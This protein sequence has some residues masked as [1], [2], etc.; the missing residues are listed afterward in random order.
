MPDEYNAC[1]V[2]WMNGPP[3][4]ITSRM[5]SDHIQKDT[6]I[7][8]ARGYVVV[9]F[10]A[11]N[12]GYWFLHCHVECHLLEGMAVLIKEY[13]HTQHSVRNNRSLSDYKAFSYTAPENRKRCGGSQP[14]GARMDKA[15]PIAIA[16]VELI[17]VLLVA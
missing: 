17:A 8:P 15:G 16:I 2:S 14:N 1:Q 10:L 3:D 7:V 9:A 6:V 5:V 4:E 11:N 13:P 12:P